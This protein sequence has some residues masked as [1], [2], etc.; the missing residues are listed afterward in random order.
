MFKGNIDCNGG[1]F[2]LREVCFSGTLSENLTYSRGYVLKYALASYGHERGYEVIHYGGGSSRS[3]E[4]GLY[5]FKKN[6][7]RI[8]SLTSM[9]LRRYG[10]KKYIGECSWQ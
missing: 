4:N 8:Q 9:L 7:G 1:I 2:P 10:T 6:L 5:R 3:L